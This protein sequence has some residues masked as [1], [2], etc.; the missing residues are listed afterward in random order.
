MRTKNKQREYYKNLLTT[1]ALVFD[2]SNGTLGSPI[3]SGWKCIGADI[4]VLEPGWSLATAP[5]EALVGLGCL[6]LIIG[7]VGKLVDTEPELVVSG[8]ERLDEGNVGLEHL[9]PMCLLGAVL[10][11]AVELRHPLLVPLHHGRV[12]ELAS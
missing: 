2:R 7:E 10:V 8:V 3:N 1:L 6:E 4:V 12:V 9:I 11:N 5:L